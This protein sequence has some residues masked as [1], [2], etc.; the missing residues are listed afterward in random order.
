MG[1]INDSGTTKRLMQKK[2][3]SVVKYPWQ[4]QDLPPIIVKKAATIMQLLTY[5]ILQRDDH[6]CNVNHSNMGVS[7]QQLIALTARSLAKDKP[8]KK[9]P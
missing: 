2:P 7:S 4:S 3:G 8:M 5:C 9:Q 1:G 6:L